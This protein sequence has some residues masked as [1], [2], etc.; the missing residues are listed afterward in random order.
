MKKFLKLLI[1]IILITFQLL[2]SFFVQSQTYSS[3][4]IAE[5]VP[6]FTLSLPQKTTIEFHKDNEFIGNLYVSDYNLP[7][8]Y[9]LLVNI[10]HTPFI[11]DNWPYFQIPYKFLYSSVLIKSS[12]DIYSL[13]III[14]PYYWEISPP[15]HYTSTII[16]TISI[17]KL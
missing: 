14:N 16:F 1:I 3:N 4:I 10:D 9:A 2:D 15:G 13:N 8:G 17:I 7:E 11:N 12:T 6:S 5:V